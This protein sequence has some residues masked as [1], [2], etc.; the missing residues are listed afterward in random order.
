MRRKCAYRE[1]ATVHEQEGVLVEGH[2]GML[3]VGDVEVL[4]EGIAGGHEAC[5][6]LDANDAP[7]SVKVVGQ[8]AGQ[9]RVQDQTSRRGSGACQ[10]GAGCV[11]QRR[12]LFRGS[13]GA[14]PLKT[15]ETARGQGTGG[16]PRWH[17]Y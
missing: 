9:S 6:L 10:S 15:P 12:E 11:G 8:S 16:R 4:L 2:G 3:L 13:G 17:A 1:S 7:G 5:H 14:T